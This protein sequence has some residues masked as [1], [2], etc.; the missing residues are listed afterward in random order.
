MSVPSGAPVPAAVPRV[1][2]AIHRRRWWKPLAA[3]G[4]ADVRVMLEPMRTR[5]LAP[6][7]V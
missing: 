5:G 7:R 6:G 1:P 3:A 2:E 4:L